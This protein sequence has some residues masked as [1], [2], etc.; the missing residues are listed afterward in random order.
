MKLIAQVKLQPTPDQAE[1]LRQTMLAYN[2]AANYISDQAWMRKSFRAYD[3]HHATYYA[4]RERFGLSAQ[5]TIRVIKDVADA[6]KLDTKRK[7]TFRRMGSMTYDSRVLRW[8]LD[9]SEVSIWTMTGRKKMPFV[10]GERQRQML[11]TL[12]GEADLVYRNGEWY[13]HQ[14]CNILEDDGFDPDE[15]LGV[16]LGIV[17][18][19]TTSDGATFTGADVLG[20]R[21][22]RRRQRKRLQAKTTSSARRVLR[23]LSGREARFARDVNH[24]IS[25]RI[26][27][28]A[29]RTAR[30]IALEDLSGIRGRVRLRRSQRDNLHSW[31]FYQLRQF[32]EYKA[33]LHGVPVVSVDPRYTSQTCSRCG[34]VAKANR[35]SQDSFL[36]VVCG[37]A[38]NADHNAAINIGRRA[39]VRPPN[40]SGTEVDFY[41]RRPGT[42]SPDSSGSI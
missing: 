12:Q 15:W 4:V 10:C 22:R 25:K 35:P 1:A 19:A 30:G 34:H 36:C 6:Y 16:D 13:L 26:V 40:V 33:Q 37:H 11:E 9:K 28:E 24:Q 32:I 3:L 38:A 23:R 8:M 17:N 31:S 2:D 41:S 27:E 5:L 18:I 20:V 39:A 7:R 29:K 14:P 21:K 42:S